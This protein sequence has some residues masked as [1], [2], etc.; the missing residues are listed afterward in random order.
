MW[1]RSFLQ[2]GLEAH[3]QV[4]IGCVESQFTQ[5]LTV[6]N[7]LTEPTQWKTGGVQTAHVQ[8]LIT[9]DPGQVSLQKI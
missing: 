9:V 3:V 2:A 8:C 1:S 4:I 6:G 7:G 5:S